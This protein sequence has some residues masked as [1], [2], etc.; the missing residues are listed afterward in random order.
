MENDIYTPPARLVE[1]A[2]R[3]FSEEEWAIATLA[4]L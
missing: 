4:N 1:W 2:R 3:Y